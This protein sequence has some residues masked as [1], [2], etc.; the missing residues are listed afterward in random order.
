VYVLPSF[1]CQ[2]QVDALG[3]E[4]GLSP[5]DAWYNLLSHA[6]AIREQVGLQARALA[7]GSFLATVA[8][9]SAG[10][11]SPIQSPPQLPPSSSPFTSSSVSSGGGG[12][13]ALSEWSAKGSTALLS[14]AAPR[15]TLGGVPR[16]VPIASLRRAFATALARGVD[17]VCLS[18]PGSA[19]AVLAAPTLN[20]DS[21]GGSG[22]S[23]GGNSSAEAIASIREGAAALLAAAKLAAAR[24]ASSAG[25]PLEA[26]LE[27]AAAARAEAE[28]AAEAAVLRAQAAVDFCTTRRPLRLWLAPQHDDTTTTNTSSSSSINMNSSDDSAV[29]SN[30]S[31]EARMRIEAAEPSDWATIRGPRLAWAFLSLASLDAAA[32]AVAAAV[33]GRSVVPSGEAEACDRVPL[34]LLVSVER[35][36][37]TSASSASSS[38]ACELVVRARGASGEVQLLRL[39]ASSAAER[40]AL[41]DGLELLRREAKE[42]P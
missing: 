28:A 34:S 40:D 31:W 32:A 36:A 26:A 10:R 17:L 35:A 41:V 30:L 39:E 38:R 24:A 4:H 5:R 15:T 2:A 42:S 13:G 33:E 14:S 11:S 20:R 9:S 19:A 18:A 23:S 27:A 22:S 25:E 7:N 8:P 12:G 37:L 6:E 29:S 16:S 3:R 21:G 1:A